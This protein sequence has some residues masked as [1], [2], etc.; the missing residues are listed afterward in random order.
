MDLNK[1]YTKILF[2]FLLLNVLFNPDLSAQLANTN[3]S[4]CIEEL[5]E[6][7]LVIRL[8]MK[9]RTIEAYNKLLQNEDLEEDSRQ[10]ILKKRDDL[11]NNR[12]MYKSQV[13]NA[14]SMFYTFSKCYYIEDQDFKKFRKLNENLVIDS[15]AELVQSSTLEDCFFMVQGYTDHHWIIKNSEL[16]EIEK[17]FPDEYNSGIKR[18]VN[19]L[20][21]DKDANQED[22][23]TA[24]QLINERLNKFYS[25]MKRKK[26][27]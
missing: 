11:V 21:G 22:M 1:F 20:T 2:F 18:V 12:E 23:N 14:F 9:K 27:Y 19:L 16:N 7:S 26:G 25:K 6:S 17:R 8:N 4:V 15:N 24:A 13:I 10:G 5:K 3:A